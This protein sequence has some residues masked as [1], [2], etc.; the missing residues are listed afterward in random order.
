MKVTVNQ[1]LYRKNGVWLVG[2]NLNWP[3]LVGVD[4]LYQGGAT[5]PLSDEQLDELIAAGLG[6]YVVDI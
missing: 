3:D 1:T 4:R 5:P 6:Q 2:E